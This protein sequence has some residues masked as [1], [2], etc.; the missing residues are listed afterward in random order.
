[1]I[2]PSEWHTDP[3]ESMNCGPNGNFAKPSDNDACNV[4]LHVAE[5]VS[6][7]VV[8]CALYYIYIISVM[9]FSLRELRFLTFNCLA[10]VCAIS[11]SADAR[12]SILERD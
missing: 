5:A 4:V 8:I 12:Y 11:G 2:A 9:Y 1:M 6:I 10:N 7:N 3:S